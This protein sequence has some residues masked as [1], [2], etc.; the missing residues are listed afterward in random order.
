MSN[1]RDF[2]VFIARKGPLHYFYGKLVIISDTCHLFTNMNI[3]NAYEQPRLTL[4]CDPIEFIS[5]PY[6]QITPKSQKMDS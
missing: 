4:L 1:I 6:G 2:K 5:I 3:L